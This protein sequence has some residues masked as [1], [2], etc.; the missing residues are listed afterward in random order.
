VLWHVYL[1]RGELWSCAGEE[2][3]KGANT[4]EKMR[5]KRREKMMM[6]KKGHQN[7]MARNK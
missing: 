6:T 7:C 5:K 4:Q 2:R 3:S 1:C